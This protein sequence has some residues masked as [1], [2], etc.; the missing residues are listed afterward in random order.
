VIVDSL[1]STELADRVERS[2]RVRWADGELRLRIAVPAELAGPPDDASPFLAATLQLAMR[3]GEDLEIEAPV[4]HRLLESCHLIQRVYAACDP[5]LSPARVRAAAEIPFLPPAR[6][7]GAF[8]S[9]GV[10]STY[11]AARERARPLTQLVFCD[12]LEPRHD[13]SV[14]AAELR[15]AGAAAAAIGLPLVTTWT[16]LRELTDPLLGD[17]EDFVAAGLAFVGHALSGG[18]DRVVIPS[19]DG[20]ETVEAVGTS[21]LLDP[22]FST[23]RVEVEHDRVDRGRLEKVM[24]LARERPDLLR[25]LK[26]CYT[27]NRPDNCGR[28]GKCLLTMAHLQAAGVLALADN[29]PDRI[30]YELLASRQI[31]QIKARFEWAAV[32][33]VL[34]DAQEDRELG[35]AVM[36]ALKRSAIGDNPRRGL[37]FAPLGFRDRR[38]KAMLSLVLEG[39]PDTPVEGFA[40]AA[41]ASE[42]ER[43]G[44][45]LDDELGLVRVL[46]RARGCHRY[47]VASVPQ[48][49]LVGELGSLHRTV[50]DGSIPLWI[51][52]DGRVCTGRYRP[53]DQRASVRA[54]ARWAAAPL[55][56]RG[57]DRLGRRAAAATRRSAALA[58]PKNARQAESVAEPRSE[59]A[60]FLHADD[61]QDRLP[62]YAGTHPVTGD[63][64]LSTWRWDP[65]DLGYAD[66]VLLGYL[67]ARAPVTGRLGTELPRL[68]WASRFGQRVRPW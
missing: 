2:A 15:L 16:N 30:D 5:S 17:W 46:D 62:L 1:R 22:L 56:W 52:E 12:G 55:A 40:R 65:V 39:S 9:R 58:F 19:S 35:R 25:H 8:F 51:R 11:S 48:G 59:P 61:A 23:E 53:S 24:W 34:G 60:G 27:E 57:F 32:L 28:C 26:V 10:D 49:D 54:R 4:S 31:R 14:R 7:S 21:P 64:L 45:E 66:V 33:Q 36:L 6:G 42:G 29:F 37:A 38:M 44:T 13:E 43:P 50:R 3:R 67:D 47:G 41:P 20:Y 63:Q 18:L 68:E